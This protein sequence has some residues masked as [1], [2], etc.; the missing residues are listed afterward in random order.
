MNIIVC[1]DSWA[2]PDK[3]IPGAHF[4]EILADKYK[5]TVTN[6]ARGGISNI[7]ICFQL[8][9]ALTNMAPTVIILCSTDSDRLNFAVG[10]YKPEHGLKNIRYT[11]DVSA[12]CGSPFVGDDD[13]PV[14]DDVALVLAQ[15]N[16]WTRP[17]KS[18]KYKLT[19]AQWEAIRQYVTYLHNREMQM[20]IDTWALQ[21]WMMTAS[22]R[23][24]PI[25]DFH[26]YWDI[27]YQKHNIPSSGNGHYVFHTEPSLQIE[28]AEL[29]VN[30]LKGKGL[31]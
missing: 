23:K 1:G 16:D 22:A 29:V 18:K 26:D 25:L 5:F 4:S 15:G 31:I 28:I 13:A 11:D 19:S 8:Q 20:T 2:T 10:D 14:I 24:I 27:I 12:T 30:D 3:R 21:Y 9:H 6:L 7:G 17:S